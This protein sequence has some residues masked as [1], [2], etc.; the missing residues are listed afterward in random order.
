MIVII[1]DWFGQRT[2]SEQR[3]LLAT[4]AVTLPLLIWLGLIVPIERAYGR[5]LE[6]QLEAV[7]RHARILGLADRAKGAPARRPTQVADLELFLTDSARQAGLTA[8]PSA[9]PAPGSSLVTIASAS[10][11]ETLEWLRQLE[12]AG[13]IVS[14]LRI[15]PAAN[16]SVAVTAMVGGVR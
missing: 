14:D 15:A 10:A 2:Q 12:L 11:P 13:Y 8:T 16:D 1:R 7:D 9:A 5:A 3:L 4:W 6:R